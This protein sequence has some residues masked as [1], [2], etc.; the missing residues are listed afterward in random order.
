MLSLHYFAESQRKLYFTR[1]ET[2]VEFTNFRFYR[3]FFSNTRSIAHRADYARRESYS[4]IRYSVRSRYA[5][6]RYRGVGVIAFSGIVRLSTIVL[7]SV[8]ARVAI[9]RV[10]FIKLSYSCSLIVV[11]NWCSRGRRP[12]GEVADVPDYR[13]PR[14]TYI[15]GLR[16][17]FLDDSLD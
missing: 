9:F 3:F 14:N 4:C 17:W 10:S 2:V 16:L 8:C 5:N 13:V 15:C 1:V 12:N 11:N 6:Q 7:L